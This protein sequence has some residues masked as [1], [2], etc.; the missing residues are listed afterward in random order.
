VAPHV[1]GLVLCCTRCWYLYQVEGAWAAR[2]K[3]VC[4]SG[5]RL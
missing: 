2:R 1:V 4:W 3:R 5:F